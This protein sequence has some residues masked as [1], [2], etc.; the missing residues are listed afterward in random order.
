ILPGSGRLR[1]DVLKGEQGFIV[2]RPEHDWR[3]GG[4]RYALTSTIETTG[5]VALFA[6]VHLGQL[7][8]GRIDADGLHPDAF[9]DNRKD[10]RYR[11]E[12]DWERVA[13]TMSN[14]KVRPQ[15]TDAQDL[16]SMIHQ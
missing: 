5:I 4:D 2:G 12:F 7:S 3:I 8:V 15:A 13:L 16:M 9:Q 6:D 1:F 14:G 10:G 11:S